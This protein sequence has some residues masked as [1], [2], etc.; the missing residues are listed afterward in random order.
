MCIIINRKPIL[1]RVFS[2]VT[3]ALFI[4]KFSHKYLQLISILSWQHLL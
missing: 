1:L 3:Y 2:L 4:M